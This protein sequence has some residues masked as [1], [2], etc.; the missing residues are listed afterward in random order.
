MTDH[1]MPPKEH[2]QHVNKQHAK[3]FGS[4]IKITPPSPDDVAYTQLVCTDEDK[5]NIYELITTMAE[6]GKLS[7]L[8][9]QGHLKGIGAQINHVHPL[10]FISTVITN[11]RLKSCMGSIFDDYFKRIN[12]MDGLGSSLSREA[13]RG[14]LEKYMS[15]FAKEVN[16]PTENIRSFFRDRDWEGLVR[17]LMQ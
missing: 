2:V 15:E 13:E 9:K 16:V 11:D 17:Y 3:F 14:K 6:H 7:L 12:F 5:A 4:M 1:P 10:K 8:M